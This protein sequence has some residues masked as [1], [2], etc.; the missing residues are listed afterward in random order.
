MSFGFHKTK[1]TNLQFQERLLHYIEDIDK[2]LHTKELKFKKKIIR[3][4]QEILSN[5]C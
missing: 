5:G 2:V 1:V 3:K 4:Y